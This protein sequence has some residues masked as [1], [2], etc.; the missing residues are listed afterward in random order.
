M[1]CVRPVWGF[2]SGFS[3]SYFVVD[4]LPSHLCTNKRATQNAYVVRMCQ[5]RRN[6]FCAVSSYA[7]CCGK[8]C[9]ELLTK[10][11]KMAKEQ[12]P[13]YAARKN[14]WTTGA[15]PQFRAQVTS[16]SNRQT[17]ICGPNTPQT[18]VSAMKPFCT[19]NCELRSPPS[20][21]SGDGS[22]TFSEDGCYREIFLKVKQVWIAETSVAVQTWYKFASE[23]ICFKLSNNRAKRRYSAAL[24][25]FAT[26]HERNDR[27]Y[28]VH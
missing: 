1:S 4:K 7:V 12:I 3:S 9:R 13:W 16:R 19:F 21:R 10:T 18:L 17:E 6:S 22:E 23:G 15:F 28:V 26:N 11:L 14:I 2:F 27:R 24:V 8:H 20:W 5:L 25:C